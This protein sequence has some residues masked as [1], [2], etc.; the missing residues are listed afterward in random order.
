MTRGGG[1]TERL[2]DLFVSL[3]G[4]ILLS[5]LFVLIAVA[6]KLDSPGPVF[7]R[8][9]R[10]GRYGSLFGIFK[11]R[12]MVVD[13]AQ[14]G[15]G[16]TSAG[17]PRITHV[18]AM[19]R[20][21]KLDELPQ[22]INVVQGEMSLVGP[23]PEDPHYVTFYTPEQRRVLNVRPGLTSPASLRFRHEEEMLA[24]ES[25]ER[26]YVQEVLPAKLRI[27]LDYLEH[28]SMWRDLGIIAQTVVA[29]VR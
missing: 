26:T 7:F 19:L 27:E 9:Q 29:L 16:I 13:A 4:L 15:P 1:V 5:P 12:S 18:G 11:F 22:L 10:V 28:R 2:F 3:V 21:I 6:I 23:R 17:D 24:G 25:W 14:R 20:R 8:G